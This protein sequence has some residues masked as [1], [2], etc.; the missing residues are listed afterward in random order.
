MPCYFF[1]IRN[2]L[3]ADDPEG[4]ELPD[5]AAARKHA[6]GAAR[7]L[8]CASIHERGGVNLD[9]RIEVADGQGTVLFS[10]TFRESFTISDNA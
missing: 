5:G 8:V 3:D 10:V 7:D 1:N 4:T 6:L 2:D 9:H